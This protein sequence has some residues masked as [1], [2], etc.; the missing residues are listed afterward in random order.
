MVR[1]SLDICDCE[2]GPHIEPKPDDQGDWVR[3]EDTLNLADKSQ[4]AKWLA[5]TCPDVRDL[6]VQEFDVR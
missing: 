5:V 4:V 6:F 2:V 3:Y 1:Y